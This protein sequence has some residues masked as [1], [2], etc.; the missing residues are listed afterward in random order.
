[1]ECYAII[2]AGGKGTRM[3]AQV[4]KQFLPLDGRPVLMHTIDAFRIAIPDVRL[5]LVLPAA[6]QAT[7]ARLCQEHHYN[8]QALLANGGDTRFQSVQNGLNLIPDEAYGIVG[9][10]DGVRPFASAR[11]I[12]SCYQTAHTHGAAVPVTPVVETLRRIAPDGSS[13]TQ[14]RNEYRLVQTP[15][16]FRIAL[17]K[18]AYRLPFS[19]LFTDDAS[20]VEAMGHPI[21]LVEGNRE[22]IKL[23]S[24][25]DMALASGILRQIR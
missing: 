16:A 1:M 8:V 21:T 15:Q 19:P 6:E 3:G 2:V 20:V 4:P 18:E 14:D 9:I 7:W 22:N 17:L 10:H 11:T 23:T 12:R 24:P 25:A 13:H 5:I